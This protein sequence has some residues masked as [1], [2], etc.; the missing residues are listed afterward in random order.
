MPA[1]DVTTSVMNSALWSCARFDIV[2]M[3]CS[4]PVDVS[5]CMA[6]TS[7]VSGFSM[8]ACSK[9][10]GLIGLPH[11]ASTR[12]TFAPS[13]W[14]III[15]RSQK[16]PLAH[17]MTLSPC[18][19]MLDSPASIPADPEPATAIVVCSVMKMRFSICETSSSISKK[20][21]SKYPMMG[22]A[23]ACNTLG[24]DELG[25]GPSMMRLG[26]GLRSRMEWFVSAVSPLLICV[27]FI[28]RYY[29]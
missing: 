3:S 27:L 12:T 6:D 7:T 14:H 20:A 13:L 11:C 8:S 17:M 4:T 19:N 29:L 25:P 28:M 23:I 24:L 26:T 22:C 5:A 10:L 16:N 18:S 21:G 1:S 9:S 15:C 2:L